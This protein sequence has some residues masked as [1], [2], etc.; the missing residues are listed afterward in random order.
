MVLLCCCSH[1]P[2]YMSYM[3]K[4]IDNGNLVA[5]FKRHNVMRFDMRLKHF[6]IFYRSFALSRWVAIIREIAWENVDSVNQTDRIWSISMMNAI[7]WTVV[8]VF[9]HNIHDLCFVICIT[10][11]INTQRHWLSALFFCHSVGHILYSLLIENPCVCTLRKN[12]TCWFR[13]YRTTRRVHKKGQIKWQ[14]Y[15]KTDSR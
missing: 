14:N 13:N 11:H 7:A 9:S 10:N 5:P 8:V 1:F 3:S 15:N 6:T 4:F 12:A 2:D